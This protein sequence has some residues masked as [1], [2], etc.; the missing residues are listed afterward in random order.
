MAVCIDSETL[1]P[2]DEPFKVSAGPGAGKTHWL[3]RHL[4]NVMTHSKTL[5]VIRKIACI[6]YTNVGTETIVKRLDAKNDTI[7]VAT[8]H[9]F[10]YANV[11]RPYIRHIA[12]EIGVNVDKMVIV[13]DSN[14]HTIGV[15]QEILK[16]NGILWK[17]EPECYLAGLKDT[18]RWFYDGSKYTVFKPSHPHKSKD[19]K[20]AYNIS[21][22]SYLYFKKWMWE[23][24]YVSFD[25]ILYFSSLLFEKFP[26]IMKILVGKY[27]YFFIDEFQDTIPFVVNLIGKMA[28]S[29]AIVGVVGDKAQSIYEFVGASAE[30]FD[31]FTVDG[32]HEYEIHGNRR[33]TK[34]IVDLL[35]AIRTEF[36]QDHLNGKYGSVPV[37]LVG[38]KLVCYQKCLE[39]CG[40]ENVQSLAFPNIIANSMRTNNNSTIDRK[41][42]DEDFDHNRERSV[43]VK[44][45][46]KALEYA[47]M[48][49]LKS[50][51]YELDIVDQDRMKT[52]S[53]LRKMLNKYKELFDGTLY[54]FYLFV[55]NDLEMKDRLKKLVKGEIKTFYETTR[56]KD[57]ALSVKGAD[58]DTKHKTIHKSKGEEFDNVFVVLGAE[59]DLNFMTDPD[60]KGNNTHRV[61]YVGVSRARQNLYINVPTL[62]TEVRNKMGKLPIR[63]EYV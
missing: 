33:C 29:G 21:N 20:G 8:I 1:I 57:A 59:K 14:F 17:I 2:I 55:W 23:R 12:E 62:N 25:D 51:W 61:Y 35:N 47:K 31:N 40:T 30:Q 37:L 10:L 52:I 9:A 54:D 60:L 56:Y 3:I 13:D 39:M 11:V 26:H 6:T 42:L 46:I 44:S 50:A 15:A 34:E 27:P 5:G 22:A 19:Q 24:G 36:K 16:H 7:E 48:N 63:I 32:M 58:S 41:I 28:R 45:L 53:M 43:V 18:A 49:D 4:R 38:D